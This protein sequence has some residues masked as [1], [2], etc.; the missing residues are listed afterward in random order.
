[1]GWMHT[2]RGPIVY[3]AVCEIPHSSCCARYRT[4]DTDSGDSYTWDSVNGTAQTQNAM[5][6]SGD[7]SKTFT[8][9]EGTLNYAGSALGV[10][11]TVKLVRD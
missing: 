6:A 8:F 7:A 11:T 3:F 10:T 2:Q 1:M 4:R 9:E 5:L